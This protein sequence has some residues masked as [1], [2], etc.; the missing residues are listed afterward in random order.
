MPPRRTADITLNGRVPR[1]LTCGDIERAARSFLKTLQVSKA[2][3]SIVFLDPRS[4]RRLNL[5]FLGHD[6]VTDV[7]TFDLGSERSGTRDKGQGTGR[8]KRKGKENSFLS[9]CSRR[10]FPCPMSHVPCHLN[11]EIYICP[12]QARKNARLFDAPFR[13]EVLRYLA[14]GLLHLS[15]LDDA[16]PDERRHMTSSEDRLL[17]SFLSG[18]ALLT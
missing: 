15:G 8:A 3:I 18:P 1:P 7:V 9:I 12:S 2:Q 5:E 16:T 17:G 11:G 4:M 14:H 6:Y 13:E 10:S